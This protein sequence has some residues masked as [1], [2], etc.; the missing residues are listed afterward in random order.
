MFGVCV[1]FCFYPQFASLAGLSPRPSRAGLCPLHGVPCKPGR[2][3]LGQPHD[4]W[5][6]GPGPLLPPFAVLRQS[7]HPPSL[8][9]VHTSPPLRCPLPGSVLPASSGQLG[10]PRLGEPQTPQRG[11][12]WP[13]ACSPAVPPRS[14]G[15]SRPRFGCQLRHLAVVRPPGLSFPL[16]QVDPSS[17]RGHEFA[18]RRCPP[19]ARAPSVHVGTSSLPLLAARSLWTDGHGLQC[20][21]RLTASSVELGSWAG[22]P[23]SA[24]GRRPGGNKMTPAPAS[25]DTKCWGDWQVLSCLLSLEERHGGRGTHPRPSPP[26]ELSPRVCAQG[27]CSSAFRSPAMGGEFRARRL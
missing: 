1:C 12:L 11:S 13:W 17:Q 18:K 20:G 23:A 10:G 8:P 21:C 22:L 14:L 24:G 2:G 3:L 9:S 16:W 27:T 6:W 19:P 4:G 15:V 5:S 7:C 26:A 25:R